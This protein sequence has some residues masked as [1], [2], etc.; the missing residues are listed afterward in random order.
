MIAN[1]N[2]FRRLASLAAA[3]AAGIGALALFGW[4]QGALWLTSVVPG[5]V[6][7]KPNT[8]VCIMALAVALGIQ[9][10]WPSSRPAAIGARLIALATAGLA[11]LTLSEYIFGWRLGIDQILML[12]QTRSGIPARMGTNTALAI[13]PN[14]LGAALEASE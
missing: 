7:M 3:A 12:D 10:I 2:L 13:A 1:S 9:S 8:S 11:I 4:T 6:P 14:G 5:L